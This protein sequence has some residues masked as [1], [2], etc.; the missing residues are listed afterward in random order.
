M[1]RGLEHSAGVHLQDVYHHCWPH[2]HH[3]CEWDAFHGCTIQQPPL[4][5]CSNSHSLRMAA[6]P[7]V[8]LLQSRP[9]LMGLQA[10]CTLCKPGDI[11]QTSQQDGLQ[12]QH[13]SGAL[14]GSKQVKQRTA[15][16]ALLW[17]SRLARTQSSSDVLW[18]C[19]SL[20]MLATAAAAMASPRMLGQLGG[21]EL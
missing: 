5:A 2:N 8:T 18:C 7:W 3:A 9:T 6:C 1:I 19:C 10:L 15:Q 11:C 17:L 20:P 4:Q 21:L 12:P 16:L 13:D 14:Q